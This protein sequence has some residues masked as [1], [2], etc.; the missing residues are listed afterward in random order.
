[1]LSAIINT[2]AGNYIPPDQ[3]ISQTILT[4]KHDFLYSDSYKKCVND[5]FYTTYL[6]NEP[7]ACLKENFI[8]SA[9]TLYG[10]K[11]TYSELPDN[12]H[13]LK[14]YVGKGLDIESISNKEGQVMML[15]IDIA[16]DPR[17]SHNTMLEIVA[18]ISK[19]LG[20]SLTYPSEKNESQPFSWITSDNYDVTVSKSQVGVLVRYVNRS[21]YE[22]FNKNQISIPRV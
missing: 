8:Q 14:K 10:V 4:Y 18:V 7:L 16:T 12:L 17:F 21:A 3:K 22:V 5:G 20:S 19:K 9:M 15:A 13:I 1:M 2:L 11:S 6:F